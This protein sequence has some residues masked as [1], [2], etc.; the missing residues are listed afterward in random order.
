MNLN[1]KDITQEN[2]THLV[3]SIV[4]GSVIDRGGTG[5]LTTTALRKANSY[6][7]QLSSRNA[8]N[9][10]LLASNTNTQT[11]TTTGG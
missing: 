8:G 4:A 10:N 5:F 3:T 6:A 9:T 11:R 1:P 2:A 7:A